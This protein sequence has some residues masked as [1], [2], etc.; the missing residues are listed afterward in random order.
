[1]EKK[2]EIEVFEEKFTEVLALDKNVSTISRT[3]LCKNN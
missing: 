3:H 2:I 1:M